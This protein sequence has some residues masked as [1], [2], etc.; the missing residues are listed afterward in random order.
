M[1]KF[2]LV[3]L[4]CAFLLGIFTSCAEDKPK[5]ERPDILTGTV[6]ARYEYR[7]FWG[8]RKPMVV[9]AKSPARRISVYSGD[10]GM[11]VLAS[12][13]IGDSVKLTIREWDDDTT[14]WLKAISLQ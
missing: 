8:T 14:V 11:A 6:I 3:L 13:E 10:V 7:Q 2:L 12:F 5:S 1:K 4:A 9:D